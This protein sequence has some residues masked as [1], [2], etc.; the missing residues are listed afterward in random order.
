FAN[1]REPLT[2]SLARRNM[3]QL[4]VSLSACIAVLG[5]GRCAFAQQEPPPEQEPGP[6]EE[7]AAP[8]A[9][10]TEQLAGQPAP[11]GPKSQWADIVVIPRKAVLKTGRIE[12]APFAGVTLNDPLIRHYSIG[13]ALTYYFSDVF[14]VGIE[15][16]YYRRQITDRGNLIG[17]QYHRVPTMN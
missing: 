5:L 16:E 15:G 14:G 12:L 11:G 7:K 17:L 13:G 6:G 8:A 2:F 1:Y 4:V 3:R 9:Q 10:P